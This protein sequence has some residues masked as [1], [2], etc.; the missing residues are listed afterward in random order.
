[1]S[2]VTRSLKVKLS[3]QYICDRI[4]QSP[5]VSCLTS[6]TIHNLQMNRLVDQSLSISCSVV[7]V[8]PVYKGLDD[9]SLSISC[10]VVGAVPRLS[11]KSKQI[12]YLALKT[13]FL[14]IDL[15]CDETP[16]Y[17]VSLSHKKGCLLTVQPL[18][19]RT[20]KENQQSL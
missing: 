7:G 19:A 4:Y 3:P 5:S 13:F 20:K 16:C 14:L 12:N 10:S 2:L 8:V 9:Q 6:S 18:I 17:L 11:S 15:R 1:M